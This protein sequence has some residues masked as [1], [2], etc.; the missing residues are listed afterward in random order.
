MILTAA[1]PTATPTPEPTATPVAFH[2]GEVRIHAAQS[3]MPEE[4]ETKLTVIAVN[5]ADNPRVKTVIQ[6]ETPNGMEVS[7]SSGE[8]WTS[9]NCITQCTAEIELG[10]GESKEG[11]HVMVTAREAGTYTIKTRAFWRTEG[12][13]DPQESPATEIILEVK[14]RENIQQIDPV[15]IHADRTAV[16]EGNTI[17]IRLS[18]INSIGNLP[19]TVQAILVVPPGMSVSGAGFADSCLGRC[20]TLQALQPGENRGMTIEVATN[21]PGTFSLKAELEWYYGEDGRDPGTAQ[22]EINLT[23]N[24]APTGFPNGNE[25]AHQAPANTAPATTT[26]SGGEWDAWNVGALIII[27]LVG[28][29]LLF[30]GGRQVRR[31]RRRGR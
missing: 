13:P 19:M 18:M 7:Q 4:G 14:R 1:T 3:E 23:V 27:L 25:P 16:E 17:P 24:P 22:K 6:L 26:E 21:E 5:A 15:N 30:G 2:P 29:S 20:N 9:E 10:P 8:D 28:G 11:N 31:S 12:N